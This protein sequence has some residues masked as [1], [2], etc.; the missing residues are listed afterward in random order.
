MMLAG[1]QPSRGRL[2]WITEVRGLLALYVLLHHAAINIDASGTQDGLWEW[3]HALFGHGHFR[4]DIFFVLSGYCLTLALRGAPSVLNFKDFILRRS[5]RLL[6][7]YLIAL[8]L[9]LVMIQ[10]WIGHPSGTHWD[11]SLPI[12][13]GSILAHVFL[14]HN[15]WPQYAI[16]INHPLWSIAVEYQLYF[17]FPLMLW[18]H[19]HLGHW[20]SW[21]LMTLIGYA[22]WRISVVTGLANPSPYGASFYYWALFSMGIAAARMQ[23]ERTPPRPRNGEALLMLLTIFV[24]TAWAVD[25]W[26]KYDHVVTEQVESFFVGL[27]TFFLLAYAP[28][29]RVFR[30][31]GGAWLHGGLRVIGERSYSLYLVHA[32]LLQMAWLYVVRRMHLRSSGWQAIVEMAIGSILSITVCSLF[33][34]AIEKPTHEWSRRFGDGVRSKVDAP[35]CA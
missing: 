31:T 1:P 20:N 33:Y 18:V 34:R 23:Q 28:Y 22:A 13:R 26:L 15:W 30:Q 21:V 5:V 17:C 9:S 4:V 7:P 25:Q 27:G 14:V 2:S 10:Y 29:W 8:A 16:N 19:R 11:T 24:L 6:L 3:V 12:A 35:S 32:P